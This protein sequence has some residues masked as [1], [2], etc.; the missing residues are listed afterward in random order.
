MSKSPEHDLQTRC[1][2]WFHYRFPHLK[3]LFFSVPNGG[4]RNKA[5]AARLKA[6]GANAGV[7]DLILQLPAGKWSSL[8]IEMK[9]G[10]SQ[11]EEQKV[12]QTCVQASGGR[13]E[14][15]R[16]YEQFVDLVTEYISQVDGRVLERLRQIHLEREEEE[17]QKIRKQYQ[18][19]R[20][21]TLKP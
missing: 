9:A 2:I 10:S 6:E 12:Y 7:S 3:P 19:R 4:Y 16:S 14:L 15:C 8:N 21:K 5:E 11:R 1:V 13:Y 18:K 20:S 17:K